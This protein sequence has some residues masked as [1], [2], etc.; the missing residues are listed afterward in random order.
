M[1]D[2]FRVAKGGND[3]G[4]DWLICYTGTDENGVN[5]YVV[6][7]QIHASELH[8]ISSGPKADA[9]LIASLL[10]KKYQERKT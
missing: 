8:N 6:T 7:N 4:E 1:K 2:I 3:A 9:E 5:Y 10:N